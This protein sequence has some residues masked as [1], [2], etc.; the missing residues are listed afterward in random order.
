MG[1]VDYMVKPF[2]PT[3]IG[4]RIRA[5]LR[6]REAPEPTEPYAQGDR[7]WTSPNAE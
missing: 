4:A 7:F 3:E 1:A 6:R 5:V 2:S